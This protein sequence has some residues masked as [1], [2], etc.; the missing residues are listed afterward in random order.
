[1]DVMTKPRQWLEMELR[2]TEELLRIWETRD[3]DMWSEE[4]LQSVEQVLLARNMIDG[5]DDDTSFSWLLSNV[6]PILDEFTIQQVKDEEIRYIWI[7]KLTNKHATFYCPITGDELQIDRQ[8]SPGECK[9]QNA[10]FLMLGE[11]TQALVQGR[12]FDFGPYKKNLLSWMPD[13]ARMERREM[14]QRW[15]IVMLIGGSLSLFLS[16]LGNPLWGCLLAILGL[17]NLLL[18]GENLFVINATSLFIIGSLNIYASVSSIWTSETY[19][20]F[21]SAFWTLFGIWLIFWGINALTKLRGLVK[22]KY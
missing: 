19:T 16:S 8:N 2:S 9:F 22:V 13:T 7:V 11:S 6:D 10:G 20:I 18:S 3:L 5:S 15:G 14:Q 17:I 1:M 21:T 12:V 4:S